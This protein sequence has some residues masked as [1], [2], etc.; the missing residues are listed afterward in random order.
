VNGFPT[1]RRKFNERKSGT[2]TASDSYAADGRA[3]GLSGPVLTRLPVLVFRVLLPPSPLTARRRERLA[4][5]PKT[6]YPASRRP[7]NAV[8]HDCPTATGTNR[9]NRAG[10][11]FQSYAKS[12]LP[13]RNASPGPPAK[14]I[15]FCALKPG[16][17]CR[18]RAA[19][20]RVS[21]PFL[22]LQP[23]AK[24]V[25]HSSYNGWRNSSR[26]FTRMLRL[27]KSLPPRTRMSV[28][29]SRNHWKKR[30]YTRRTEPVPST[31]SVPR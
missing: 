14:R 2:Q 29:S 10:K 7:W 18:S 9:R 5:F 24:L 23:L 25:A 11:S 30:P 12:R 16:E 20:W 28:S 31:I 8:A 26:S 19:N 17:V 4:N 22:G 1:S 15:T 3:Q 6:L 21:R 13:W 27:P